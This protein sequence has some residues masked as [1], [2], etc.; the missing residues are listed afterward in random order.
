MDTAAG[1]ALG[2]GRQRLRRF[3]GEADALGQPLELVRWHGDG[4]EEAVSVDADA[5]AAKP[6]RRGLKTVSEPCL[7]RGKAGIMLQPRHFVQIAV[8]EHLHQRLQAG[9]HVCE[10]HHPA[11]HAIGFALRQ[12]VHTVAVAMQALLA[13]RTVRVGVRRL[14]VE[15]LA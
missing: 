9:L 13:R 10:V 5:H 11:G 1:M 15:Y 3:E 4:I 2:Q 6:F 14:E 12:Q 8:V 7:Q